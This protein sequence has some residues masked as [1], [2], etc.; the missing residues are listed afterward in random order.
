MALEHPNFFIC[1]QFY[2]EGLDNQDCRQAIERL[3]R[4]DFP[5]RYGPGG[6]SDEVFRYKIPMQRGSGG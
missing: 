4:G 2:G 5:V 3:P 1:H 6:L